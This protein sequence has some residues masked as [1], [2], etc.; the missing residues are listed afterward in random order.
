MG[1]EDL[2]KQVTAKAQIW[3]GDGYDEETKAAVRAM[4]DNEDKTDLIE[5]FYKDLE[6]GT[7]GLRGIMGAGTNRMN[8]YTVGAATQ[9]LSNYLKKAFAD[10]PQIKVAIGHDCRNNSR[11]FA[12]VAADVFSANGIK[13]YLFDALRPTPEVSF[14]IRELGCQS[15]VI[16]TASH[17][18]KEYN[19]YKAYW[20]DGAQMI[21]P[22]DKN[23]IDEVNKITSVKD[24]KFRGNAELIEIIGEEIDRRYLDRIKTLSLSPEAIAHHHDMKIVY[25][26]IHGTGVKLIPASLKNFGFTNIIHV[27]EQDVVSGDFPTVVSPNPEEPAA[28]DMAIKK[29]IETDAEL[30]MASDPDADRIGIAVRNDK[31]EFIL[32]NGNQI[33]MI[34][35]NYLMTRNKEL[36]LLKGNEYIVKTIVTT[37]TIKT[38]AEQNG[39]KMYDCYTGFKWIASVIRE[40]EGKARYI[41]GGEESYGFLPEDFVRDKD[42]VSSISLMAE[43][44]AWAKDKGMTMYQML[45][46][47]Y[48][49]YGYSKEKGISVVR[50]GKSGAEEIVAMMKNFRENPMKELG[51]SPVILIKDYASLEATD[52]V[53]GTKSKLDM[54]VT[55]NVL[56]YFSADGSKVSI[57]PS[58]TE[59]KIKFYIEVRGIKMDNYADYDAANA[60]ADAKIEAIKKELGI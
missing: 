25:T 40:N 56:Q 27:P 28:L 22:H 51:G 52:V 29:A 13:V 23:T 47:I 55:S 20:N 59:P 18:P 11:K 41:G 38:I 36:G 45:Q 49:K 7:G 50:K 34:F 4:L 39:F 17:N 54:P 8:I 5:A 46:D 37:E 58:G 16:L 21:A 32:V 19:G 57:R 31:G 2:L 48:I 42:S 14:A 44:A 53:N 35:L 1:N 24:V 10:L 6:F 26:P 3:L 30:V 33:V 60:A 9:G 43:I 15:G 12:E